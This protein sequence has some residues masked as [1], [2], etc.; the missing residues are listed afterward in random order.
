MDREEAQFFRKS[1]ASR[2][3]LL[4]RDPR[5]TGYWL[6][7][8]PA[9]RT[10]IGLSAPAPV[11]FGQHHSAV[12]AI[13][14]VGIP[15][16]RAIQLVGTIFLPLLPCILLQANDSLKLVDGDGNLARDSHWQSIPL[17]RSQFKADSRA[18][19]DIGARQVRKRPADMKGNRTASPGAHFRLLGQ[20]APRRLI[21]LL[22]V[23]ELRMRTKPPLPGCSVV[24]L[25]R[26][27]SQHSSVCRSIFRRIGKEM[28]DHVGSWPSRPSE[29]LAGVWEEG[30][31]IL[32][33]TG[34]DRS[35]AIHAIM[36]ATI[37]IS[38]TLNPRMWTLF[39]SFFTGFSG[40]GVRRLPSRY[41]IL[42]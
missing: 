39:S 13:A 1:H 32:R 7:R 10:G 16:K 22:R 8:S 37:I 33:H 38:V 17:R 5:R 9:A 41:V 25:H 30:D 11:L 21:F 36:A 42:L 31:W 40:F 35:R 23:G 14:L 3:R 18:L 28:G 15:D 2:S 34:R 19:A 29:P 4:G 24:G 12:V 26:P 6:A 20:I 27:F